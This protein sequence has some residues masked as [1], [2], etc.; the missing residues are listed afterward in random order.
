MNHFAHPCNDV[1][2]LINLMVINQLFMHI[3]NVTFLQ[4][5]A[6]DNVLFLY[7][8]PVTCLISR[9]LLLKQ[10]ETSSYYLAS[11]SSNSQ[12]LFPFS[13]AEDDFDIHDL[14]LSFVFNP[15]SPLGPLPDPCS[16]P[17]RTFK[18]TSMAYFDKK[19]L[20]FGFSSGDRYKR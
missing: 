14:V 20:F 4:T 2:V 6:F 7:N 11:F 15:P 18:D 17:T 13:L 3:M 8:I 19:K 5:S 16:Q 12:I 9:K 10:V 1:Q